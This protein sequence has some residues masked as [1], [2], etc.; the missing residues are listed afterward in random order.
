MTPEEPK[1][2]AD[3]RAFL[4]A[5]GR[6]AIITPPAMTILL[7]TSLSSPA[8]AASGRGGYGGGSGGDEHCEDERHKKNH[9]NCKHRIKR[10]KRK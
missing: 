9:K 5:A 2:S 8:I 7:S 6:F 10:H 4:A 3:R 1:A